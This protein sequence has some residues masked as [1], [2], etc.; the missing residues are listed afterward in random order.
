MTVDVTCRECHTLKEHFAST[1]KR[2]KSSAGH[3][4]TCQ[5]RAA[6][7]PALRRWWYPAIWPTRL[8]CARGAS[9]LLPARDQGKA[10]IAKF[11][12]VT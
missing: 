5:F 12:Y 4:P 11:A 3:L 9:G 10:Y 7:Q 6:A 2:Q 1:G 8:D